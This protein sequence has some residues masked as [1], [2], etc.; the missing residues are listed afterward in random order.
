[1]GGL[2]KAYATRWQYTKIMAARTAGG[3]REHSVVLALD[4][5]LSIAGFLESCAIDV[6]LGL[7]GAM[8]YLGIPRVAI[9]LFG[10]HVTVCK[11]FSQEWGP[12]V[13]AQLLGALFRGEQYGSEDAMAV[14]VATDMLKTAPRGG[15]LTFVI[16]DGC[17]TSGLRLTRA[18]ARAA[19]EGVNVVGVGSGPSALSLHEQY[20]TWATAVLPDLLPEALRVLELG[21]GR[22]K[23]DSNEGA[24]LTVHCAEGLSLDEIWANRERV[25]SGLQDRL[26]SEREATLVSG[27]SVGA[28]CID[29]CFAL[30]TTGSMAPWMNV[31][32]HQLQLLVAGI[33]DKVRETFPMPLLLR[34]SVVPFRD[35]GDAVPVP[36]PFS[37]YPEKNASEEETGKWRIEQRTRVADYL[38]RIG[39]DGGGDIPED[40]AGALDT[41][42]Q[43][44]WSPL[45]RARFVVVITDAP[46][47]GPTLCPAGIADSHPDHGRLPD[48]MDRL[49][50]A[51]VVPM[52]CSLNRK[53]TALLAKAMQRCL[54]NSAGND[55]E[56]RVVDMLEGE[57]DTPKTQ[58]LEGRG[59]HF[60]FCLDESGSMANDW[61]AVVQSYNLFLNVRHQSQA[62]L[63]RVSV[64]Q[65]GTHPRITVEYAA[66][67]VAP[68]SLGYMGS[69]TQFAPALE[70]VYQVASR[71]VGKDGLRPMVVFMTDG[72]PG[73]HQL[74]YTAARRLRV[75]A[76]HDLDFQAIG[77]SRHA[78]LHTL[79][80]VVREAG[81]GE[82]QVSTALDHM[83]LQQRFRT[84]ARECQSL[85]AS[86]VQAF[87]EK[88]AAAV[89]SKIVADFL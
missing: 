24:Q 51:N 12:L 71:H 14:E 64:V 76:S 17:T 81:F 47:H 56:L 8:Q 69:G 83:A 7:I 27:G 75:L 82:T 16:T 22:G 79:R 55:A 40:I 80:N 46:G 52:L 26:R 85:T 65:F 68:R 23:A 4:V 58:A 84:I 15:R 43:A 10:E 87:G 66:L 31:V 18:L 57:G 3:R 67:A 37:S 13:S 6:L 36:L 28:M 59:Y 62:T 77:F 63:D 35:V 54:R 89:A 39:T 25:F 1:M 19:D 86:L 70:T 74:A 44:H 41:V 30:D 42:A 34:F 72:C 21:E 33:E 9:I 20:G 29:V 5:S 78:D 11:T 53:N 50:A 49:A 32:R 61:A 45:A 2:I 88:I 60:I 38:D 48:A 73:D